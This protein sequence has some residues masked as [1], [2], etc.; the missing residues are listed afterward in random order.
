[1]RR[2]IFIGLLA[3]LVASTGCAPTSGT[4][5]MQGAL[6]T[7]SSQPI[8]STDAAPTPSMTVGPSRTARATTQPTASSSPRA[9]RF[10]PDSYLVTISDDVRVRSK[11]GVSADSQKLT[12]LLPLGTELFV[13]AGP[14]QADGFDW[15]QVQPLDRRFP[16]GWIAAGRP[17]EPW[18]GESEF[19]CGDRAADA[20]VLA[21]NK[22]EREFS[23]LVCFGS[24]KLTFKATMG[25]MEA[26]CG[27][28]PCC[29]IDPCWLGSGMQDGWLAFS[30][31]D[32]D[33]G[34]LFGFV[35]D[36]KVDR[37]AL[38]PFTFLKR[39]R[40]RVSGQFDHPVSARCRPIPD[41]PDPVPP[42][43]ATLACR[44]QF[45]VTAIRVLDQ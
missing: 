20:E 39:L 19:G 7:A 13:I 16:F 41:V 26:Q 3:I 37:A 44:D 5:N 29:L 25:G 21:L 43:L 10:S 36:P 2:A 6:A 8:R 40:V 4:G 14:K 32:A 28:A 35:F 42:A 33:H 17:D 31:N 15:Y 23:N 1:M 18:V 34:D 22:G 45:V 9:I 38:P 11:P 27:V 24:R 30:G 12:P